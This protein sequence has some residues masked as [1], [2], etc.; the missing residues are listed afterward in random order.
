MAWETVDG[1]LVRVIKKKNFVEALALVNRIGEV[2][3]AANHHPDIC[4]HWNE[5]EL[6]L[7]THDTGT[8]TEKD[9]ALAAQIDEIV[10]N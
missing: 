8:I 10:G 1:K 3:E 2:A 5:V 4:I 7:W 9:D 6:T